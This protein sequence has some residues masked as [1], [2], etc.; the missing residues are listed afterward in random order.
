MTFPAEHDNK[1][2]KELK[3]SSIPSRQIDAA[4]CDL[5]AAISELSDDYFDSHCLNLT[6]KEIEFLTIRLI[7]NLARGLQGQMLRLLLEEIREIETQG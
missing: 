6:E 1:D 4:F 5:I 3:D 2:S 7:K